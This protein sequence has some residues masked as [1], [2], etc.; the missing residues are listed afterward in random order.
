MP[1]VSGAAATDALPLEGYGNGM[2]FLIAGQD[3][4][5]PRQPP[6]RRLQVGP[7]RLLPR[8]RHPHR[9]GTG[10]HRSRCQE[11]AAG[12]GRSINGSS[13]VTCQ[14]K[15][16]IGQRLLVQE[17]V[18]GSPQL[19]PEIPW[20]IVGV[21]A[22]E[23]TSSLE[24]TNREG[25]YVPMEQSP[26]TF[27]SL[28]LRGNVDADTLGKSA[29]RAVHEVDPKQAVTDI[30]TLEQIKNESSANTRLRTTLIA[31]FA[32]LALLLSAVGIYGVISYTV[33][34]R[35]HE[36]GVRA[37]LGASAGDLLRLVLANGLTLTAAGLALGLAGALGLTRLLGTLLFGVGAR[38][39]ITL[40]VSADPCGGGAGRLLRP[41][42]ARGAARPAGGAER[43]VTSRSDPE[44]T[45]R[46]P[47]PDSRAPRRRQWTLTSPWI[48]VLKAGS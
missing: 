26:T 29:T 30:R 34:Q 45:R 18:A 6:G 44:V 17:I 14:A 24:G 11:R 27:V 48:G 13:S 12:R 41:G 46:P 16:P 4:H 10:V 8:P 7:V 1:G 35:T 21:I 19:G 42:A 20:E 22:D 3:R 28:V 37:A 32:G 47:T 25:I 38:D 2:P 15:D 9:P 5:R 23:R 39:P 40:A 36:M 33:A 31:V 43:D